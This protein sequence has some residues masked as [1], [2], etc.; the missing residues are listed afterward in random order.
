MTVDGENM[1]LSL[2]EKILIIL[3]QIEEYYMNNYK[4]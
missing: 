4:T 3:D 1:T 2:D